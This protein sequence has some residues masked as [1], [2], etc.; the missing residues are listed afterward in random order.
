M[1]FQM[2]I[3]EFGESIRGMPLYKMKDALGNS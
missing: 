1:T 2:G 3:S